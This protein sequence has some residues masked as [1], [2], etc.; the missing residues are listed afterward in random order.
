[1]VEYFRGNLFTN[2]PDILHEYL[3]RG[4]RAA[5]RVRLLLA[6]TLSPLYGIYSGFELCENVP[7][8]E[9]SEEY[10]HSEKYEVR[11]RAFDAP[12]N[13]NDDLRR[14]NRIRREHPALQ[15]HRNLSFHRSENEQLLFYHRHAPGDDLL[16]VV[17]LDPFA[18][19]ET[20]VQVPL[21]ALGLGENAIYDV[22]DL[23]TGARYTWRGS[24]NYVR[25]D[26]SRE[27]GHVLLV[28]RP[29]EERTP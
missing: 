20:M 1:M 5:F 19:Q 23:L 28:R 11:V 10:L 14:I 3:Q 24:R 26:P 29:G 9:G 4:G 7:I 2:T 12:G 25:L 13:L 21:L 17:N 8:H 16:V 22:E 15:R 27:P 18:P 6:A